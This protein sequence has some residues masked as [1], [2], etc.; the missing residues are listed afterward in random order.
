MKLN[1]KL[2]KKKIITYFYLII[3][4]VNIV[5][6]YYIYS[7]INENV[8]KIIYL[9]EE[10]LISQTNFEDTNINMNKFEA[11]KEFMTEKKKVNKI[12][13]LNNIFN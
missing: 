13:N 1:F 10:H 5:F 6:I 9:D 2:N 8:Y 7:F 3:L 4:I 12:N 11:V